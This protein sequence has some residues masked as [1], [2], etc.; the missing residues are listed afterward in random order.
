MM[1]PTT[2][3]ELDRI[4]ACGNSVCTTILGFFGSVTSTPVKF[5]GADSCAIHKMRRPSDVC[6]T[7]MPS[8]IPPKPPNS[9]WANNFILCESVWSLRPPGVDRLSMGIYRVAI[10]RLIIQDMALGTRAYRVLNC[11]Y[12]L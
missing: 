6:C 11:L 4:L 12:F 5:L 2:S 7:D 9:W 10:D 3:S 1:S 8:P